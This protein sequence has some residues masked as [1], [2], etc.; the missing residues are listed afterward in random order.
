[1]PVITKKQHICDFQTQILKKSEIFLL[2]IYRGF[3]QSLFWVFCFFF[4]FHSL[5]MENQDLNRIYPV[6]PACNNPAARQVLAEVWDGNGNVTPTTARGNMHNRQTAAENLHK[7]GLMAVREL[8]QEVDYMARMHSNA[9]NGDLSQQLNQAVATIGGH[10]TALDR[11]FAARFDE[12]DQR[13]DAMDRR[14]DEIEDDMVAIGKCIPEIDRRLTTIE[15]R[16][17]TMGHR[18]EDL[19][20]DMVEGFA[21]MNV[22]FDAISFRKI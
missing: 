2:H 18:L 3:S 4:A 15:Q 21:D 17:T 6:L 12:M 13:L 22:Q 19:Q 14:F 10:L 8:G 7:M 11:R 1:M 16:L 20:N 9:I 5:K